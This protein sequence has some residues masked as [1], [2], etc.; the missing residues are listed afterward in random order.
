MMLGNAVSEE[1]FQERTEEEDNAATAVHVKLLIEDCKKLLIPDPEVILGSW[2]LIDA[3]PVYVYSI[4]N[5][6]LKNYL[7]SEMVTYS[8]L[9]TFRTGDPTETEMDTILILTRDSYYV[10]DYD[11][12]IDKVT[13][14]QRV[15]LSDVILIEFGQPESTVS[16]FK[17]KHYHCI[18]ISYKMG[19]EYGYFH[20][21]RSTNLRFFNNMAVVIKTAEESIGKIIYILIYIDNKK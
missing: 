17:N 11:D 10:A 20:M 16:I 19:T 18:R 8:L 6:L 12:Q 1:V 3:D 7:L 21:F 4:I 14:Y 9:I 2:G 15:P 5:I 13:N